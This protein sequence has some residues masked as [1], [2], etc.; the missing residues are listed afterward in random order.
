MTVSARADR[1]YIRTG[2]RSNRFIL[3]D[4]VAPP[5]ERRTTGRPPVN[6]AFVIDRSGSMSGPKLETAKQALADAIARLA[7]EDRF[8][9]VAYDDQVEIV[10]ESSLATDAARRRAADACRRIAAGN[11]TNL[12]EGWLR[13]CEQVARN[14]SER[15]INR[16]LLLTDGLANV[17]MTDPTELQVHAAE[18]QGAR[19]C[20]VD[21]RRRGRLRRATA[22]GHGRRGRRSLL[23]HR[24]GRPDPRRDDR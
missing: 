19:R 12:G 20:D 24:I 10:A 5:A 18:L 21:I 3:V 15:G 17:G 6:L 8:A 11:S 22:A 7:P 2:Y 4:I 14:L 23:L 9:V 13:G 1:R 16:V